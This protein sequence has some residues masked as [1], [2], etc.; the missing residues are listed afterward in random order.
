MIEGKTTDE[1]LVEQM[2][3]VANLSPPNEASARVVVTALVNA[4]KV[5]SLAQ[6]QQMGLRI[7][8]LEA[9]WGTLR[10]GV[11]KV[12]PVR[13]LAT[14]P[15]YAKLGDPFLRFLQEAAKK[16]MLDG[17]VRY[18]RLIGTAM[19]KSGLVYMLTYSSVE[20]GKRWLLE[21]RV[22][23]KVGRGLYRP[24]PL[25]LEFAEGMWAELGVKAPV[26]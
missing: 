16:L 1:Y 21:T 4:R 19:S 2:L 11:P 22:A 13:P 12:H 8:E 20:T 7:K 6:K 9:K 10:P 26:K 24:G 25:C 17:E 5:A 15:A 3:S 14:Y 23:I 18:T